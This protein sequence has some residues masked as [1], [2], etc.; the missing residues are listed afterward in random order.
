M[1]EFGF[2]EK[3]LTFCEK[4]WKNRLQEDTNCCAI[5]CYPSGLLTNHG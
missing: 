4:S 1:L 3:V 2:M 5:I